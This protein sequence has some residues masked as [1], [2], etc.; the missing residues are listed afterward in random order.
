MK[1]ILPA[2]K[3]SVKHFQEKSQMLVILKIV[4][5]FILDSY[6]LSMT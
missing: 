2:V 1:R 3:L 4:L 6:G 5:H